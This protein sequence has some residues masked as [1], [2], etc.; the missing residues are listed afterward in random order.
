MFSILVV[1]L[2][3]TVLKDD[4]YYWYVFSLYIVAILVITY[5]IF[6][7]VINHIIHKENPLDEYLLIT[8]SCLGA[9][10]L[11]SVKHTSSEFMEAIMVVS[12]FQISRVIEGVATNKSKEAINAALDL[13]SEYAN[14]IKG[15]E[16]VKVE[17]NALKIGDIIVI[18]ENEI[19]PIDGIVT[20]GSATIDTSSLTG[21]FVPISVKNGSEVF[22][23]TIVKNGSIYLKVTKLYS[24]STVSKLIELISHSGENKSKA[25]KFVTKFARWY[26]PIVFIVSLLIGVLGS[27]ITNDY[28][29]YMLLGLKM[30]VVACPCAIV[31]SVPMAYFSA[32]GLASK[33]GIVIKGSN[34]LDE[35]NR[36]KK[37]VL[38]K[39]GTL[40][41]GSFEIIE[42][43]SVTSKEELI[44]SLEIGEAL[45][46]HPIAKAITFNSN[47]KDQNNIKDFKEY[48]GHGVSAKYNDDYLLC[49]NESFL[50][51][52]NIEFQE[53]D[54]TGVI[55]YCVK[56]NKYLGY[57]ILGDQIKEESYELI[58]SL[59]K[60]NI[61][62]IL[63]S[64]D[65]EENVTALA[66]AL[67]IDR[68]YAS[69]L[70]EQ[71]HELLLKEKSDKYA[72]SFVGDGVNDAAS[73]KESDIG[74]AMGAI[75]SD[76]AVSNA[77]VIIMNDNPMKII[78]SMIIAK[79]A[80][81]TAIFNIAVALIIKFGIE[82]AAII[83]SSIGK[84]ELI[85]MWAA[86]L[87]DTGLTVLLIINSL[88]LLYRKIKRNSVK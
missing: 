10:V 59:H 44:A 15:S 13:R 52:N 42:T 4:K 17:P 14:L 85:P 49:G 28:Y 45:S 54:K 38:D 24:D 25:D 50:K 32:L 8:I 33:N 30:L 74:F 60:Y 12:L 47:F 62:S 43:Y 75:G 37:V 2:S 86:V 64:G 5:D 41:K 83:T 87:A 40:T 11:A 6:Y 27:V 84:G 22:S 55:V 23:G 80:R 3:F 61:E 57:V 81:R 18:K 76:I 77:D 71:K 35:I 66:N 9:F 51:N 68:S 46:N 21:E 39:T 7:K 72:V 67:H 19:V 70:P 31:I 1:I 65:K 36:I 48:P 53:S 56:N 79:K 58:S 88:L 73:I 34:Y 20:T 69:L 63:L 26:T 82:I 29:S 16:I 78:D